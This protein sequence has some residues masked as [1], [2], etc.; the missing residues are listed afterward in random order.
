MNS[1]VFLG[2]STK[3]SGH[4]W[5]RRGGILSLSPIN[6]SY[7][8][9]ANHGCLWTHACRMGRIALF[10]ECVHI[11]M[12]HCMSSSWRICGWLAFMCLRASTWCTSP[13]QIGKK[14]G[15]KPGLEG[16]CVTWIGRGNGQSREL[17]NVGQRVYVASCIGWG[18]VESSGAV[19]C[20]GFRGYDRMK[21]TDIF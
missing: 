8:V 4:G 19:G 16:S 13:C 12:W 21:H 15:T 17:S 7:T 6:H 3:Q 5:G 2:I 1:E 14:E 9:L 18:R 10:S 11:S 20:V